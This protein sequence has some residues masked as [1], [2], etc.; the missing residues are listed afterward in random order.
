MQNLIGGRPRMETGFADQTRQHLQTEKARK[1]YPEGFP[2]LPPVPA[3]RYCDPAFFQLER[4][5]VF[6]KN[7][8][9]VAHLDELPEAGDVVLLEQFPAPTLLGRGEDP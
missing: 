5:Y 2:T 6:G 3:A 9:V 8:L 7:W 1:S 4:E